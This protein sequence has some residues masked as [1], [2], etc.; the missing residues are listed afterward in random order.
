MTSDVLLT[1][2]RELASRPNACFHL[3]FEK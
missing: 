3:V 1:D 2:K